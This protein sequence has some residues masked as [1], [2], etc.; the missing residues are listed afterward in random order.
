MKGKCLIRKR[1]SDTAQCLL[2]EFGLSRA[3]HILSKTDSIEVVFNILL[4][5]QTLEP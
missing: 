2:I 3:R 5:V 1:D 4:C